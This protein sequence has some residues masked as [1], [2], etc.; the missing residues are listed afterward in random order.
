MQNKNTGYLVSNRTSNTY[1]MLRMVEISTNDS[2]DAA[3]S[4]IAIAD[5]KAWAVQLTAA[6]HIW[7]LPCPF[8]RR[9]RTMRL[10]CANVKFAK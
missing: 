7:V 2:I 4:T 8:H 3:T 9:R 1:E 10:P 5:V 6:C